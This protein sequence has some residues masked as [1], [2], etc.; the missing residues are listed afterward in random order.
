MDMDDRLRH[1]EQQLNTHEAVCAERYHGI[2]ANT[3]KLT[4]DFGRMN[5]L[6]AKVGFT[7]IV[8]MAGI[9]VKLVFGS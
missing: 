3:T 9:L 6:L 7:L 1:V 5:G 4:E 2:I 8:G